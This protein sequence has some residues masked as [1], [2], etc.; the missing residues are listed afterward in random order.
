MGETRRLLARICAILA[1]KDVLPANAFC[2]KPMRTW[3]R[4]AETRKPYIA[5]LTALAL[6]C[7]LFSA[8][9]RA[10]S[11]FDTFV[12]DPERLLPRTSCRKESVP[13]H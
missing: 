5:I 13:V 10:G 6:M 8:R 2:S 1:R 9:T 4:G 7:A 11:S 3:L 12:G